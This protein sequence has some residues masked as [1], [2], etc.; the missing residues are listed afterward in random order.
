[1]DIDVCV[2]VWGFKG[3][4]NNSILTKYQIWIFQEPQEDEGT[5]LSNG[6]CVLVPGRHSPFVSKSWSPLSPLGLRQFPPVSVLSSPD[7]KLWLLL[8]YFMDL[9]HTTAWLPDQCPAPTRG[10]HQLYCPD[11]SSV[12]ITATIITSLEIH[13]ILSESL[14]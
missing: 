8:P 9:C 2:C 13:T 3:I 7:S 12:Q 11:A 10:S 4:N 14:G 5:V 6:W 1:M